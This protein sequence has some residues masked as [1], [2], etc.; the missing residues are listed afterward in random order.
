MTIDIWKE[1]DNIT[2]SQSKNYPASTNNVL[3][4]VEASAVPLLVHLVSND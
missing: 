2:D 1:W 3:V 4:I